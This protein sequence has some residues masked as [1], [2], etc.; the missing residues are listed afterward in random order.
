MVLLVKGTEKSINCLSTPPSPTDNKWGCRKQF[1]SQHDFVSKLYSKSLSW[2]QILKTPFKNS[3]H[4]N[5]IY[6]MLFVSDFLRFVQEN[7]KLFSFSWDGFPHF[8]LC[9]YIC[10][11]VWNHLLCSSVTLI[12]TPRF[13]RCIFRKSDLKSKWVNKDLNFWI[14]FPTTLFSELQ[15]I[16]CFLLEFP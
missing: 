13:M 4:L 9:W 1:G 5:G 6:K 14:D 15:R 16:V 3:L 8:I 11:Y 10:A 2:N 7:L 12:I